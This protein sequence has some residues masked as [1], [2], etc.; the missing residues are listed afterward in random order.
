MG[1]FRAANQFMRI[2]SR[3]LP[4]LYRWRGSAAIFV[5]GCGHSGTTLMATILGS[6]PDVALIPRETRVF[7]RRYRGGSAL[8]TAQVRGNIARA[9]AL[10]HGSDV[11]PYFLEKT[12]NHV[13]SFDMM[14]RVFPSARFV[15]CLRDP[16]DT[17]ASFLER[18]LGINEAIARWLRDNARFTWLMNQEAVQVVRYE[19]LVGRF[20]EV[21]HE[22]LMWLG[23]T[24]TTGL[25]DFWKTAPNWFGLPLPSAAWED[26]QVGELTHEERRNAQVHRPISTASVGRFRR[27]LSPDE[28]S[29]VEART[30]AI[31]SKMGY[32]NDGW[33]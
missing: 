29:L 11:R 21:V 13:H 32:A 33:Q 8:S 31:A 28:I 7:W 27:D 5:F 3:D 30:L 16:R 4:A 17:V 9:L 19:E 20:E 1:G 10:S 26:L 6:H 12:P 18:G 22:L 2:L 15:Y 23:L 14:R 25:T 24:E